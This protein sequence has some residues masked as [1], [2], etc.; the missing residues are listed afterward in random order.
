MADYSRLKRFFS[1]FYPIPI[2]KTGSKLNP[3]LEVI[4]HRG[5]LL[6]NTRNA[7]YAFGDAQVKFSKTFHR[8]RLKEKEI[9]SVLILGFGV[10]GI[11]GILR[12]TLK[13]TCPITG[14]ELDETIIELGK[15]YFGAFNYDHLEVH[16]MDAMAFLCQ[17]RELFDL[18][19]VDI[20][21]DAIVP[22]QFETED[23][24]SDLYAHLNGNGIIAFNKMTHTFKLNREMQRL[25]GLFDKQFQHV[26]YFS[27]TDILIARK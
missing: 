16:Q 6:L 21:I 22:S 10:G 25:V 2:E 1:Y 11:A 19:I 5:R 4:M 23:F 9:D 13:I 24:I 8:I 27:D 14:V 12:N 18:I 7:N 17:N 3:Y 15:K 26:E 20:F